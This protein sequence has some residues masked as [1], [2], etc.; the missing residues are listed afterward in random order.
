[1]GTFCWGHPG[2]DGDVLLGTAWWGRGCSV[3]DIPVGM[4][5]FSW[6]HPGRDEDVHLGTASWGRG[7]SVGDIPVGLGMFS[8]WG[9][10]GTSVRH[11]WV[12]WAEMPRTGSSSQ[13]VPVA[14]PCRGGAPQ[15]PVR[16]GRESAPLPPYGRH[17]RGSVRPAAPLAGAAVWLR[18]ERAFQEGLHPARARKPEPGGAARG[19]THNAP[20]CRA[21]GAARQCL[22]PGVQPV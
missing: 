11:F 17:E 20:L 3:G 12:F 8:A 6:G 13:R 10:G 19:R 14:V 21:P 4:G 7:R 5:T 16:R 2:R 18:H 15:P 9:R 1:M 22:H